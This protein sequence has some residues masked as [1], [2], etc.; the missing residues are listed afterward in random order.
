MKLV[1]AFLNHTLMS[2]TSV[3]LPRSQPDLQHRLPGSL[4]D[5]NEGPEGAG[6]RPAGKMGLEK[7][8]PRRDLRTVRRGVDVGSTMTSSTTIPVMTSPLGW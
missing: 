8:H 2:L 3:S 6:P 4:H 5:E 7:L 1:S